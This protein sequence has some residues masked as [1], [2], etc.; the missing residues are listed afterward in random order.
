MIY[1]YVNDFQCTLFSNDRV[2]NDYP[3][4]IRELIFQKQKQ[5]KNFEQIQRYYHLH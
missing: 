4:F 2:Q 3:M 1:E 5:Y